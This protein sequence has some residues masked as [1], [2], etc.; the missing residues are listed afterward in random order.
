M[1]SIKSVL[2]LCCIGCYTSFA[3]MIMVLFS[4]KLMQQM[5]V[6]SDPEMLQNPELLELI[7]RYTVLGFVGILTSMGVTMTWVVYYAFL[8]EYV[9][10]LDVWAMWILPMD[11]I[12]NMICIVL[13][14]PFA[15]GSYNRIC[16]CAH[17][18][19]KKQCQRRLV[20]HD[21]SEMDPAD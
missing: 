13:Y 10:L 2:T 7:T 11:Q 15:E 14:L 12:V 19:F 4:R 18:V 6:E 8:V 1:H 20:Q 5:K 9:S 3:V 21:K 16:C 17:S